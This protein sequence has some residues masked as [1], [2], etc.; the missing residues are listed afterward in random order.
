MSLAVSSALISRAKR[1]CQVS[2]INKSDAI[3]AFRSSQ[4]HYNASKPDSSKSSRFEGEGPL[5]ISKKKC[6]IAYS[7]E[8]KLQAITYIILT[9]MP[10]RGEVLREIVLITLTY[11]ST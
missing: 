2:S 6:Y 3:K 9:N 5:K 8:K 1:Q 10:K 7:R 11:T 4:A